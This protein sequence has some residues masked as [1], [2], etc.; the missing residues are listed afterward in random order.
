MLLG[1]PTR[2]LEVVEWHLLN[3]GVRKQ[4]ST[5]SIFLSS[6]W[7]AK[8]IPEFMSSVAG[9]F[10]WI[11]TESLKLQWKNNC[12][13]RMFLFSL[14]FHGYRSNLLFLFLNLEMADTPW[15]AWEAPMTGG[16]GVW[17]HCWT[18]CTPEAP[19]LLGGRGLR[20]VSLLP[21]AHLLRIHSGVSTG[22]TREGVDD[23]AVYGLWLCRSH[24]APVT[25]PARLA[26][27]SCYTLLG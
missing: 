11:S 6:H 3:D 21:S 20:C 5:S 22:D 4:T 17:P 16:T 19:L 14:L 26:Y 23:C 10:G 12:Q 24:R 2:C 8:S 7:R 27:S 25:P 18:G 1:S 9:G 15:G 13:E